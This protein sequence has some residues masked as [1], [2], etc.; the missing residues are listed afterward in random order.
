MKIAQIADSRVHYIF[1]ADVM[2]NFAPNII[3]KDITGRDDIKEG[4]D[5]NEKNNTYSEHVDIPVEPITPQPTNQ[6]VM[7]MQ[8][9]VLDLVVTIIE[10]QMGGM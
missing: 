9:T 7:D 10:N 1:E 6:E 3:L 2:P 5:Y 8:T 4:W